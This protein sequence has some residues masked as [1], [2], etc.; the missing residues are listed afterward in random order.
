MI[1]DIFKGKFLGYQGN[2]SSIKIILIRF[3]KLIIETFSI[4]NYIIVIVI[5]QL[6]FD[7][8]KTRNILQLLQLQLLQLL[9]IITI[10][11]AN[12]NCNNWKKKLFFFPLHKP[13]TTHLYQDLRV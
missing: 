5:L 12:C 2:T 13:G 3:F 9:V 10:T 1:K 7:F 6:F 11:I 4:N 8:L